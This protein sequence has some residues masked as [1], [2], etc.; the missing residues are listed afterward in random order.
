MP[1]FKR[2]SRIERKKQKLARIEE[3]IAEFKTE[4]NKLYEKKKIT[5]AD[6]YEIKRN[7]GH[8]E[9]LR[10]KRRKLRLK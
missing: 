4:L 8:L 3:N 1:V 5:S 6:I 9:D 10:R 7:L 2:R